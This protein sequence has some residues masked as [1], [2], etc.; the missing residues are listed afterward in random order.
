MFVGCFLAY[1]PRKFVNEFVYGMFCNASERRITTSK[2][3]EPSV[4]GGFKG[5]CV[6]F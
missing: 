2:G 3:Y 6:R 4:C 5:Q 1:D